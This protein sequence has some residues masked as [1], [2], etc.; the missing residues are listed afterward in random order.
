[1]YYNIHIPLFFLASFF[2]L[3]LKLGQTN[4]FRE[5]KQITTL[6]L[7]SIITS[8]VGMT[9]NLIL[10]TMRVFDLNWVGQITTVVWVLFIFYA[11]FR[12]GLFE[13]RFILA[14]LM[15]FTLGSLI[16]IVIYYGV[17]IFQTA[18]YGSPL[19]PSTL[20]LGIPISLG[21]IYIYDLYKKSVS[22]KVSSLILNPG[23]DPKDVLIKFNEDVSVL[24]NY[25]EIILL[26]KLTIRQTLNPLDFV[27]Y[28]ELDNGQKYFEPKEYSHKLPKSF[29]GL[30]VW[31][32]EI[33][34]K[35]I[36][37]EEVELEFPED[38]LDKK[39][40]VL[41]VIEEMKANNMQIII[42][43]FN[44]ERML[45]IVMLSRKDSGLIYTSWQKKFL[46]SLC[47]TTALGLQRANL[48]Q[49]VKDFNKSLQEKIKAAT[50]EIEEKNKKLAE[51]LRIERDMLDILGHELRTPITTVR[52]LLG[53]IKIMWDKRVLDDT[54]METYIEMANE[55]IRREISLLE[56]ILASAK[57]DN[58]KLE[59]SKE[60][61]DVFDVVNDSFIAYQ[62]MAD[63]K[64]IK[65]IKELPNERTYCLADRLRLQQVIDNL[66]SNAIKYTK[67]GTVTIRVYKDGENVTFSVIDTG[68]GISE[69]DMKHLGEKFFRAKNYVVTNA[70]IGDR[71]IIRPGGTGIGLY[72]VYQ[73]VK[74][75]NGKI[76]VKSKVGE[77][78]TFS[79]TLPE[80][81]DKSS[82]SIFPQCSEVSQ[83]QAF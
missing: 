43:I 74:Y 22:E 39:N 13:I 23:W 72:V 73:L 61:V 68:E 20:L 67:Y 12:Y 25:E 79:V 10:P 57:I 15:Y 34:Y 52:N 69:E 3:F 40:E 4:N 56:T 59:L 58:E 78:S 60:K 55:S 83:I 6:L 5:K 54:K 51:S 30:F 50:Y 65:L 7:G 82:Q 18:I 19:N 70:K 28:I 9:T 45:G 35:P 1:M 11:I 46:Q 77:G 81:K 47:S 48:Y 66:V 41:Q 27:I 29:E 16:V 44:S 42:P 53:M 8:T 24:L 62:Q 2:I 26:L 21:F 75:M 17:V 64:G 37:V 36:Q 32:K 71:Q 33:E 76:D 49:E 38:F 31:W 63:S 14:R 80:Y